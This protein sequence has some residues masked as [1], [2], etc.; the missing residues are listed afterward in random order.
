MLGPGKPPNIITLAPWS[1]PTHPAVNIDSGGVGDALFRLVLETIHSKLKKAFH[2]VP[3]EKYLFE[4][5]V[6]MYFDQQ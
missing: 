1:P 6:D 5:V 2:E 3:T 4:I